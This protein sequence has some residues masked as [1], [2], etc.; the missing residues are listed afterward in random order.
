M[1][2]EEQTKKLDQLREYL[3]SIAITAVEAQNHL[4][5]P[6]FVFTALDDVEMDVRNARRVNEE[7]L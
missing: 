2:S 6:D 3:Q 5:N 1:T 7:L 4:G